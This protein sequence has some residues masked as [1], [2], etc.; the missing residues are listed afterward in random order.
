MSLD[1]EILRRFE[2]IGTCSPVVRMLFRRDGT[3]WYERD[4]PP[5]TR[6]VHENLLWRA[7]EPRLAIKFSHAR[8]WHEVAADLA[9]GPVAADGRTGAWRLVLAEDPYAR[10]Q[11]ERATGELE[12][13]SDAGAALPS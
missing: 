11:E 12:L 7:E 13:L 4:A 8:G 3:G 9:A 1:P 2:W 10:V 6:P 5:G